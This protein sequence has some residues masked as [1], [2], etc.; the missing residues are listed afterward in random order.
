MDAILWCWAYRWLDSSSSSNAV[1]L[2]LSGTKIVGTIPTEIGD[3]THLKGFFVA[4]TSMVG[5]IPS[6]IGLLTSLTMLSGSMTSLQGRL[7]S[8]IGHLRFLGTLMLRKQCVSSGA[9]TQINTSICFSTQYPVDLQLS[10]ADMNG[11]IPTELG[12]CTMLSKWCKKPQ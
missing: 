11:P 8:E 2:S 6:E 10:D 3:L 4:G 1:L 12:L 7:P 5:S 9:T